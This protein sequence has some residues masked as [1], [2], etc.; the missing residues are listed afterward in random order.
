MRGS[1]PAKEYAP[2][3]YNHH[4][5]ETEAL[6]TSESSGT[7]TVSVLHFRLGLG[8]RDGSEGCYGF[9]NSGGGRPGGQGWRLGEGGLVVLGPQSAKLGRLARINAREREGRKEVN[10]GVFS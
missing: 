1:L 8:R 4:C 7:L 2:L 10:L 5:R 6:Q 3:L 9:S